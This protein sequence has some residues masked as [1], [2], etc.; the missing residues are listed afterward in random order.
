MIRWLAARTVKELLAIVAL[1]A[2]IGGAIA[3]SVHRIWLI[4]ILVKAGLIKTVGDIALMDTAIIGIVLV[5]FGLAIN[6][7]SAKLGP[8]GFEIGG[9]D[10]TPATITTTTTQTKV[11]DAPPA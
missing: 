7:R 11:A 5:G 8:G 1:V 4:K 3:L 9:G 6:K 10:E 2:S